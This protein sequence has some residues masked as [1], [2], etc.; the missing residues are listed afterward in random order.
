MRVVDMILRKR[1]GQALDTAHI[2]ELIAAYS[3]DQVPDYQMA[4]LA[5][6]IYFQGLNRQELRAW[7]EA[8]LDSGQ[9]LSFEVDAPL[10]D[11]HSTGGVGDKV[12]LILAPLCAAAGLCVPMISGR[13]LGHT[14]G[15]LD[16]LESIPGFD[17]ALSPEAMRQQIDRL[18]VAI[19]GQTAQI[20]PADR[21]LYALRD[22][23][24][25]VASVPLI[26]ASIMSKKLAEGLDGL[27][28]DVKVGSGAFMRNVEHARE[29]GQTMVAL[30]QDMGVD[31]RVLLTDMDQ[32]LGN[33]VG[34]ALELKEAVE[35]LRGHGPDDLVSLVCE[36]AAE[37][38]HAGKL[39]DDRQR[40]QER[41]RSLLGDGSAL[42]VFKDMIAAQGGDVA[43]VDDLAR[44][45]SAARR[46]VVN[47]KV[48]G[49]VDRFACLEV[50]A[51]AMEL[52]AGR[53]K[54]S[55]QID[56]AV[57][58]ELHAKRGDRVETGQPLATLH[59]HSHQDPAALVERLRA[60][61]VISPQAPADHPLVL[62]RL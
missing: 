57:G 21:R 28:L 31:T 17:V 6:A 55:D 43:Y 39:E 54:S 53:A 10:V 3:K 11:K 44:L 5:M 40:A 46:T 61:M 8:M 45:P 25:T 14:G 27:V 49:F 22:V 2:A 60:A 36:L 15:T 50:G 9:R 56:H 1:E 41:A 38:M 34:N 42:N 58:L 19:V 13:G 20:V 24:G 48:S 51:V 37:M 4:A 47:A 35:T 62:E 33:T 16:K 7:T 29:L 59:H 52:G 12:S 30:G 23:T 18:G 26:T 32:P